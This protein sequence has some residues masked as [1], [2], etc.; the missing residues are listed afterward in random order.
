MS[1]GHQSQVKVE[2]ATPVPVI[3]I[4][5]VFG[6]FL[7]FW[8]MVQNSRLEFL[9]P[10]VPAQ[11][12]MDR[13][14][15]Q[16]VDVYKLFREG[17]YAKIATLMA[18]ATFASFAGW[19]L[20]GHSYFM[21]VFGATVEQKIGGLRY[22]YLAILGTFL[23]WAVLC[24]ER[25]QAVDDTHFYGC[26]FLLATF[27]GAGMVFPDEKEINTQW[28]K[29]SRGEIFSRKEQKSPAER[30]KINRQLLYI[31]FILFEVGCYFYSTKMTP[32]YMT[33]HL[34]PLFVSVLAGYLFTLFLVW[35]ATGDLKEGA[36]K[37]V[38]LRRYNDMLKLDVPHKLAIRSVSMALGL[39]EDR[40][41]QWVREKKG[42]MQVK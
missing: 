25:I 38:V 3:T 9:I 23:P 36:I 21:W 32:N 42:K 8:L 11:Q 30:Y 6:F 37:L 13:N 24:Y 10:H 20:V 33:F 41:E 1:Y 16:A 14:A 29:R 15:V 17:G 19:Q 18:T 22:I 4:C 34:V 40:V 35:S 7:V 26:V 31:A 39:P 12:W 2:V 28:F 27:I 5:L